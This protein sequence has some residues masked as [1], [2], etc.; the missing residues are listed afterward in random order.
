MDVAI[1]EDEW[2][3][4]FARTHGSRTRRGAERVIWWFRDQGCDDAFVETTEHTVIMGC[5]SGRG[6]RIKPFQIWKADPRIYFSLQSIGKASPY[7]MECHLED[8]SGRIERIPG[9]SSRA[10]S[11]QGYRPLLLRSL[12]ENETWQPFKVMAEEI[13]SRLKNGR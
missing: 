5:V 11:A 10:K 12:L 1:W 8:L 6:E 7:D 2:L 9:Y 4:V 13:L 3:D